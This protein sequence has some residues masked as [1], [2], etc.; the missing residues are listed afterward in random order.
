MR[1]RCG[2]GGSPFNRYNHT[3]HPTG[4]T[5]T[6]APVCVG[7]EPEATYALA[8]CLVFM[9]QSAT[10]ILQ[11]LARQR[12][13]GPHSPLLSVLPLESR[14]G[15]L[16]SNLPI[17]PHLAQ[18]WVEL[19]GAPF[20]QHQSLCLAA[21]RRGEP[22][23]L[24]GGG[25]AA[26][27]TL[28]FLVQ[29]VLFKERDIRV[30]FL[31]PNE[32]AVDLYLTEF[33]QLN[34]ELGSPLAVCPV[35]P[36]KLPRSAPLSDVLLT[37][38][39]VLHERL[40]HYHD[41]AWHTFWSQMGLLLLI[42]SDSYHGVALSHL[43]ALLMRSA[44]IAPAPPLM[45]ATIS[46][47]EGVDTTLFELSGLPWRIIPVDDTP[48]HATTLAIWQ[49][50]ERLSEAATLALHYQLQGYDVHIACDQM[51]IP[52]LLSRVGSHAGRISMGPVPANAEVYI[53]A[54][55]PASNSI[56]RQTLT[57]SFDQTPHITILVLGT[58]PLE[59]TL[60]R[61][62]RE[63][64]HQSGEGGAALLH[65]PPPIW[66]PPPGNVYIAAHHLLCA[67]HERPLTDAEVTDWQASKLVGRLEQRRQLVRL[68]VTGTWQPLLSTGDPYEGFGLLTAG[69]VDVGVVLEHG[70]PIG[71]IAM[72]SFDR[73]GFPGAALPP[74]RSGYR[75]VARD[76]EGGTLTLQPDHEGRR[77]F[78]LRRCDVTIR[79]E[80]E[81]RVVRGRRIGWGRATME[82]EVYG[83]RE[84]RPGGKVADQV[85]EPSL[86]TRWTAPALW[87]DLPTKLRSTGQMVGWS[88]VSALPLEVLCQPIDLVPA[89]DHDQSRLYFVDV[90]PGGNGL[91]EW[92]AL[93]LEDMLPL[94]YDIALDCRGD[95]LFDPMGRVDMDWLL[96]LLGGEVTTPEEDTEGSGEY[97]E[98]EEPLF[99]R[100]TSPPEP[101][102][103][104]KASAGTGAGKGA[105]QREERPSPPRSPEPS[106]VQVPAGEGAAG[107]SSRRKSRGRKTK[108]EGQKQQPDPEP[109]PGAGTETREA[110]KTRSS[111]ENRRSRVAEASGASRQPQP[112]VPPATVEPRRPVAD[113]A[114]PPRTAEPARS[115]PELPPDASAILERLQRQRQ[116]EAANQTSRQ[117]ANPSVPPHPKGQ[118]GPQQP[119]GR[120]TF[121][122]QPHFQV[123]D[124]VFC[125]PYGKGVVRT[126]RIE[127]G[128]ELLE[129]EFPEYGRLEINPSVSLVRR[130]ETPRAGKERETD[131]EG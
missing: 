114:P 15:M 25:T 69:S 71:T 116:Q 101:D 118:K 5:S 3:T 77:T 20:C 9:K 76:E 61:L 91:A 121:P 123:G 47:V 48:H 65:A 68:P 22:F 29:E 125:R 67:A 74:G 70:E 97:L 26:R 31:L 24:V 23:A 98:L 46:S 21:L 84:V 39:G 10:T 93:A 7:D 58:L 30:M 1:E 106:P 103:Q 102:N 124:D 81:S 79:E 18:T 64:E 37:T 36:G 128:H 51:E 75:V 80:R 38:P 14:H 126:S 73:W 107:E 66:L 50:E 87:I 52:F 127:H 54:G 113:E 2:A 13:H 120:E 44:R 108:A 112:A 96:T 40:L 43:A 122:V 100:K 4:Q 63:H 82:E 41:R 111:A 19:T 85:L 83:Y 28:H 78:P 62:V 129:I 27:Q 16:I 86:T 8:R 105:G 32:T 12:D 88:L 60:T 109:E 90:Q 115:E 119:P 35:G 92:L 53:F 89:Y 130:M 11:T 99:R 104:T 33:E 34:R 45:A 117:D 17:S 56:L 59:R 6:D 55:Y 42:D 72:T 110:G 57:G 95:V 94:A 49:G 131:D